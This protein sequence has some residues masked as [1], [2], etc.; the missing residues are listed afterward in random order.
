MKFLLGFLIVLRTAR[1]EI[2]LLVVRQCVIQCDWNAMVN[3]DGVLRFCKTRGSCYIGGYRMVLAFIVRRCSTVGDVRV[4]E[5]LGQAMSCVD[6][7]AGGETQNEI[8]RLWMS[9]W[10]IEQ[11]IIR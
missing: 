4:G 9:R 10:L 7:A 1:R 3:L 5:L 6:P 8:L 2:W 11:L